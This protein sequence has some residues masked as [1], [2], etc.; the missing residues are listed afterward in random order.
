MARATRPVCKNCG[1]P[2]LPGE[3]FC[4]LMCDGAQAM[5]KRPRGIASLLDRGVV[6]V[7]VTAVEFKPPAGPAGPGPK[8]KPVLWEGRVSN[9]Q[10]GDC[11]ARR[12][13]PD[14]ALADAMAA[15]RNFKKPGRRAA[16][17]EEDDGLDLV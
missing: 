1:K 15:F 11:V 9:G 6:S 3:E 4:S 12:D 13:D 5:K 16:P 17:E 14:S 2:C 7:S 8:N 10:N